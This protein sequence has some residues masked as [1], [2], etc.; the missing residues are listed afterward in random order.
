[1]S[2]I[3]YITVPLGLRLALLVG[4]LGLIVFLPVTVWAGGHMVNVPPPNGSNDTANLQA[5]L[6]TCV[7]YGKDCTVQLAAGK[8]LTSQLVA[9]NFHGTFK[10]KGKDKTIIEALPEL[11]V[12]SFVTVGAECKP[13]TTDCAW[14]TL[15]MFVD[16]DI[17]VS[18]LAINVPSV[19]AT[20]PWFLGD[21]KLTALLDAVRVMGQ[22]RTNASV[23]RVAITGVPDNSDTGFLGFNL[24]NGMF[25][26]GEFPRSQ[27]PFDF[28]Y[29]SGTFS[30]TS[31]SFETMVDG[32]AAGSFFRDSR[33]AIGGS[34]S[35]G[36]VFKDLLVGV[37]LES[38]ENSV[39][40]I[41]SNVAEGG[42]DG[43]RVDPWNGVIP[44]KPSLFLIHD[45]IFK[46]GSY[47]DGLFLYDDPATNWIYALIYNNTVEPQDIYYSGISAYNTTGTTALNNKISGNGVYGIGIWNGTHAAR[48]GQRCDEASPPRPILPKSCSMGPQPTAPWYA[49]P[50]TTPR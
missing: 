38:I 40:E 2:R 30:V 39:I 41:S 19:P 24:V 8:Y 4:L 37:Y 10:G 34:P 45:N 7:A 33:V 15:I 43:M 32:A 1:M 29:L 11:E 28:Y 3:N 6:D 47:A 36:N 49:R 50:P 13:N 17:R 21:W 5:S 35:A 27:N 25:F 14:P 23:E 44:T 18:D 9:Y 48:A 22:Y 42:W 20:K 16:G 31:S 26:A 46:P 12:I